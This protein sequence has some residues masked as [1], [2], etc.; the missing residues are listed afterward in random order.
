ML[1]IL[2]LHLQSNEKPTPYVCYVTLTSYWARWRKWCR[3]T[4]WTEKTCSFWESVCF[5]SKNDRF[6]FSWKL[7]CYWRNNYED[8]VAVFRIFCEHNLPALAIG[9]KHIFC[10]L[11]LKNQLHNQ[12]II[13]IW[14]GFG[15]ATDG[16][17]IK[18]QVSAYTY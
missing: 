3:K 7:L 11:W 10:E 16:S 15:C 12:T 8:W 1:H 2:F 4:H 9:D 5:I 6:S 13:Q 14:R 18:T 17:A